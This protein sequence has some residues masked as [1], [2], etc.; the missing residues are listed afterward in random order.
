MT[1]SIKFHLETIVKLVYVH[2]FA[3]EPSTSSIYSEQQ[4]R[5]KQHYSRLELTRSLCCIL[6]FSDSWRT[7]SYRIVPCFSSTHRATVVYAWIIQFRVL[8]CALRRGAFPEMAYKHYIGLI[9][10]TKKMENI[11]ILY[12]S[13]SRLEHHHRIN[14]RT[15]ISNLA[16]VSN[17][18]GFKIRYILRNIVTKLSVE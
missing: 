15:Y 17:G 2:Y 12:L 13:V 8:M 7:I 6:L 4:R 1:H 14:K 5:T 18:I 11:Y 9:I 16:D 3:L 10:F